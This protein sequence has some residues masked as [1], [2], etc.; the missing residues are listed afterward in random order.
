[1]ASQ[2]FCKIWWYFFAIWDYRSVNQV[3]KSIS[4]MIVS[5]YVVAWSISDMSQIVKRSQAAWYINKGTPPTSLNHSKMLVFQAETHQF[6]NPSALTAALVQP[7]WPWERLEHRREHLLEHLLEGLL[8]VPA[9]HKGTNKYGCSWL[10]LAVLVGYTWL[11]Y[12][13]KEC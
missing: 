10:Y 9:R 13:V 11:H 1:M 2:V 7:R 5:A 4:A 6:S 3:E 12:I 8:G